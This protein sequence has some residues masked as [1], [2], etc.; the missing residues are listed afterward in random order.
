MIIIMIMII[1]IAILIIAIVI[2]IATII[3]II[4]IIIIIYLIIAI[5]VIAGGSC[6][7]SGLQAFSSSAVNSK[8]RG[9]RDFGSLR[10][11]QNHL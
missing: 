5:L 10:T 6:R 11:S 8:M 1:I 4:I 7:D 2:M 9:G 3:I